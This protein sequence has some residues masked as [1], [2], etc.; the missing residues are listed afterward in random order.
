MIVGYKGI[1]PRIHPSVFIA[2]TAVIVGDVEIDEG[3]S[4]WFG[5]VVR[6]DM[7]GVKIGKYSNIQ[8]NCTIH[9]EADH[10]VTVGDH[11]TVGHN[12]IVH[13]CVIEDAALIGIGAILL[14]GA[15]VRTGATVA[16]GSVVRENQ[17]VEERQLV[18]GIPAAVKKLQA[19]ETTEHHRKHARKYAE[20]A[21][22]YVEN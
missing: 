16:A 5:A 18:A 20:L 15:V 10:P 1:K 13:G 9:T 12:A 8:D 19:E 3:S 14:N 21:K 17:L 6:G 11:V 22:V 7:S 2:P 4:V